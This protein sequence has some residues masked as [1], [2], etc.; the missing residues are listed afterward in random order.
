MKIQY[1]IQLHSYWHCGSGLAAGADLDALVIKD[2]DNLPYIPGKTI[3]GLI[4]EAVDDLLTFKNV[5]KEPD[6]YMETFGYFDDKDD[7]QKAETFFGNAVLR[8]EEARAIKG[9]NLSKYLYTSLA[10]T[11]I[12]SE[13]V[14]E[15][16]SLRKVEATLPCILIGEILDIPTQEMADYILEAMKLIKNLG[17]DRNRGLGR[18][19][20][21]GKCY[22]K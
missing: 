6:D 21:E 13:G 15:D 17:M 18:C 14:A 9:N 16:H 8:D 10:S 20:W 1:S 2:A 22:D 4:R 19:T 5:S 12:N 7:K 3:K 11:E